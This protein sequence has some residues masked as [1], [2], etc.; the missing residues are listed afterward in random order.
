M[1]PFSIPPGRR[2]LINRTIV[3]LGFCSAHLGV[4]VMFVAL[5]A[6]VLMMFVTFVFGRLV[7]C[8]ARVRMCS[9]CGPARRL[10]CCC[11]ARRLT[12]VVVLF[13]T[14]TPPAAREAE[15][16]EGEPGFHLFVTFRI[17]EAWRWRPSPFARLAFL[18][19]RKPRLA[20]L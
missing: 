5:V 2:H 7:L 1:F 13:A 3:E 20:V 9:R 12:G 15:Q 11:S 4:I 17:D 14:I 10:P 16:E 8:V 18:A 19:Q 6:F